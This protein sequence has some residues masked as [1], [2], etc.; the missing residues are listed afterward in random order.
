MQL[1]VDQLDSDIEQPLFYIGKQKGLQ[2]V[3][4]KPAPGTLIFPLLLYLIPYTLRYHSTIFLSGRLP[5]IILP[6]S[7]IYLLFSIKRIS[8]I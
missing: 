4:I 2:T 1:T 5:A 3:G 7:Y 8:L 6:P